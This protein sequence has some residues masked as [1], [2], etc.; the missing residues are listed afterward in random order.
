M[1]GV[2]LVP[3]CAVIPDKVILY[4]MLGE[5]TFGVLMLILA[6]ALLSGAVRCR[7][8]IGRLWHRRY[9]RSGL[10]PAHA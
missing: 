3:Y 2:S 7:H 5:C 10:R 8:Q 6:A 1:N 9:R 4:P